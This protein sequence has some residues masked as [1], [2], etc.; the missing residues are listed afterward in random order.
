MKNGKVKISVKGV[1]FYGCGENNI[2]FS[3]M[4]NKPDS[5]DEWIDSLS[6][7]VGGIDDRDLQEI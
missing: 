5:R 6:N 3:I 1:G 7:R 2:R 4:F